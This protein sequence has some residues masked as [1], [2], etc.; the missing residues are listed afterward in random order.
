MTLRITGAQVARIKARDYM[1]LGLSHSVDS[2][3]GR[4]GPVSQHY[5]SRPEMMAPQ[6]L[7]TGIIRQFHRVEPSR[8]R[9]N[10]N[11][12]SPLHSLLS[13]TIDHGSV[14]NAHG[15]STRCLRHLVPKDLSQH[16]L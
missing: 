1:S 12:S 2:P 10:L 5:L 14:Y 4:I 8:G 11:M 15:P 7:A 3:R 6:F 13:R 16:L 9:I